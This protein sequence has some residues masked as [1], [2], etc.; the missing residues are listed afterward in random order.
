MTH[1]THTFHIPVM[2]LSYTIDSPIKVAKFGI[3]SVVSI[4]EDSLIERMREY[5]YKQYEQ[6]YIPITHK[7]EDYRAKRVCDYL[8]LMNKIVHEQF[9]KL[10]ASAF[11][12]GSE[13]IQYF[14]ML[15]DNSR[16]KQL[17][18]SMTQTDDDKL[19]K[20]IQKKLLTEMQPGCI[21]VNI[22]TKPDRNQYDKNGQI[23]E[24]GSDAITSLRGY[25]NSD[26]KNSSIIFSA[27]L[28]P[29]L[30]S[31]LEKLEQFYE[32]TNNTFHKKITIKVSDYR[33]ALI[34]GKYLAKKG[35]WVSEFRIESGLN[36]GGHAFA[37][38]GFL[39]G[40]ILEEF[41]TKRKDIIKELFETYCK[42]LS[43]KG[44]EIPSE[45]PELRI[46]AQGGIGTSSEH[47][48]LLNYF[49]IDSAGWGSPFLLV[50]E[51]TTVD[52]KTL[53]QLC[54]A[55]EEDI[56]LS[57]NSPL[58]VRFN[59]LKHTTG[60]VEK[61]DRIEKGIPGSPCSEKFLES[62]TEFT[63][64]PICTA[65]VK[66]QKLK[67][68]QLASLGLSEDEFLKQRKLALDK[69]CLCLGLSNSALQLY[70]SKPLLNVA[71]GVTIC[72]GPNLAYFDKIATLKDMVNHIYGRGNLLSDYYRP[73]FF[74]KEL[75]LYVTYLKEQISDVTE[76]FDK[77]VTKYY[78]NFCTNLLDGINYYKQRSVEFQFSKFD[79]ERELLLA[80]AS[81]IEV[82][83]SFN[84][85]SE[86]ALQLI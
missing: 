63:T 3:S 2:G 77:K 79:I 56:V 76:V 54:D 27:G 14:E 81:I 74:I 21:D 44:K 80:E 50:P 4:I 5:Y 75:Q 1:K 9:D 24:D 47:D 11:E 78:Q 86:P 36:C 26:L 65:S 41:K 85:K 70:H 55:K 37:S 43:E 45:I 12:K 71:K 20:E 32:K 73:H 52:D 64:E 72:P 15:P 49:E 23:I 34:Q 58:G 6:T 30:Y 82:L 17:Y 53:Q 22:M 16:M 48:L 18:F 67:L 38:D 84:Q 35:I 60:E 33:S 42:G 29:R 62:N 51:A 10:K 31:Y 19:K 8:N 57:K 7:E 69:E 59:Y 13:L 83:N 39:M 28:N 68:E 46:T 61:Y 25:A 40:P 66:Y